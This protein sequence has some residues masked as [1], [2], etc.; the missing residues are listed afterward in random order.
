MFFFCVLLLCSFIFF[1][2]LFLLFYKTQQSEKK[3]GDIW[4][5]KTEKNFIMAQ[6]RNKVQS[7]VINEKE[8]YAKYKKGYYFLLVSS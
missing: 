3:N 4:L 7:K 2:F 6:D 1:Y 8:M 5:H